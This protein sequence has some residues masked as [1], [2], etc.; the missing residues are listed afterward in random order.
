MEDGATS[1]HE[2]VVASVFPY[3]VGSN[4]AL[5]GAMCYCDDGHNDQ[6]SFASAIEGAHMRAHEG[7]TASPT[8]RLDPMDPARPVYPGL[9]QER[10]ALALQQHSGE[11]ATA[12]SR[13]QSSAS[14]PD[15][16][17]A[18]HVRAH[19]EGTASPTLRLDPMGPV[20][21][22]YPGLKQER[23]ASPLQQHSG[24]EAATAAP[25]MQSFASNPEVEAA[26]TRSAKTSPR[27]DGSASNNPSG[28]DLS[29]DPSTLSEEQKGAL[30]DSLSTYL[31]MLGPAPM[32]DSPHFQRGGDAF[33]RRQIP[34]NTVDESVAGRWLDPS[35]EGQV[36]TEDE[37]QRAL[38]AH[39]TL[40]LY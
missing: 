18:P 30:R 14:N 16:E 35:L 20:R 1:H 32:Q 12:A 28:L 22:V 8:P 5:F 17:A 39:E 25:R 2:G 13:M 4:N 15:V 19:E 21:P 34:L 33:H 9:M 26:L 23:E 24:G 7:G 37:L 38:E 29:V 40:T 11:A 31:N 6:D 27:G 3:G 10:V 36:V